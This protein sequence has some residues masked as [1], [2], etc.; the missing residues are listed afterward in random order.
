MYVWELSSKKHL[1]YR[2]QALNVCSNG[3]RIWWVLE[4]VKQV[5][6]DTIVGI[7]VGLYQQKRQS[8]DGAFANSLARGGQLG[9]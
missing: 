4:T 3:S 6:D 9:H 7:A 1:P 2:S 8:H 5:I